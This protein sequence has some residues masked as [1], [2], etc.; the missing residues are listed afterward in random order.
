MDIFVNNVVNSVVVG[1]TTENSRFWQT[2]DNGGDNDN[3]T[4]FF[5]VSVLNDADASSVKDAVNGTKLL[6]FDNNGNIFVR[7]A[8]A[9]SDYDP[10]CINKGKCTLVNNPLTFSGFDAE[11]KDGGV[12]A[13]FLKS[14]A[15][16]NTQMTFGDPAKYLGL[17]YVN[18][19]TFTNKR[20]IMSPNLKWII[21]TDV[22]WRQ[23]KDFIQPHARW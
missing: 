13:N 3:A 5:V 1:S 20:I 17:Q 7:P 2:L 23:R 12:T 10:S 21:Y 6:Y 4:S 18:G 11:A 22:N 14:Q 9:E 15:A 19:Q 8:G 16:K